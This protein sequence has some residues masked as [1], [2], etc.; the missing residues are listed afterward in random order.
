MEVNIKN[1]GEISYL[2]ISKDE[3]I[4]LKQ[5]EKVLE[6]LEDF[7]NPYENKIE[8]NKLNFDRVREDEPKDSLTVE[9]ALMNTYEKK[10]SYFKVTEFV[11]Q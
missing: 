11:E 3:D 4:Y 6:F 2:D 8:E 5:I 7:N 9:E 10:Y 1:L